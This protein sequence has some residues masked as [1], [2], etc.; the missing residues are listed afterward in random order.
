MLA[1]TAVACG[2]ELPPRWRDRAPQLS[3]FIRPRLRE[4]SNPGVDLGWSQQALDLDVGA[5]AA[6]IP[7]G[8]KAA[9]I[10]WRP[11]QPR[12]RAASS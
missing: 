11:R 4:A 10:G 3:F 1:Y 8:E 12:I 5:Q 7:L 9:D 6:K 2:R